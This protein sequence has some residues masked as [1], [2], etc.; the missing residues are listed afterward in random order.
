MGQPTNNG[1]VEHK[2]SVGGAVFLGVG[3]MVGAGIFALLGEAG[4]LAGT[5]TWV[6]FL[7]GGIIAALLGY[8]ISKLSVTYPS[9]GGLVSYLHRGFGDSHLTGI[10]S[11][12]FYLAGVIVTAMV[13]LSFG[14]YARSL[15]L[16][17][18]AAAGWVKVFG[19]LIVIAMALVNV[20]GADAVGKVQSLIV[21]ILLGVF[22]V[23]IVA[24]FGEVDLDFIAPSTYPSATKIVAAVA[25]TF[26]AYLGFA[27]IS[28]T[29]ESI[30]DPARSVP[31]A[32]YLALAIAG[33]LYVLISVGV[34]GTL[35]VDEVIAAG[36][37]ALAEAARPALGDAGF[38]MMALAALLATASSVNA[39]LFAA[40]GITAN[41]AET[42]QFPPFFGGRARYLGSRGAAI[43]VG[44]VL[45][46][47]N[48]FDLSTIASIG[49]AV[50]LAI[51]ALVG[52]S[53]IKLRA[54]TGSKLVILLA[55]V[56][57]TLVVLVLFCIDT[58]QNEPRVFIA[59]LV[60]FVL[61]VIFD[62]LWKRQR[63]ALDTPTTT[64][65]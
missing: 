30:N 41:L 50:A 38:T 48:F 16:P 31:R 9:K 37:T 35:T 45:V 64:S 5:A 26:F 23:F 25:L 32:T 49:S 51:F 46:L 3:A 21:V 28:T 11:W 47:A 40:G 42:R 34:Y 53:G 59:M 20:V 7:L 4:A 63:G 6:A 60:I 58:A 24:T 39:N 1:P 27:V 17:D 62:V 18:D 52:V 36:D 22:A 33:G 19:S 13:A 10:A 8:A 65:S 2:M 15:L 14:S 12:L 43:S 44:L 61:T 54:Q 56:I 57:G 55:A 29:A